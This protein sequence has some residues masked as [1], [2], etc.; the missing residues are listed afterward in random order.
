MESTAVTSIAS[1]HST[2]TVV[3]PPEEMVTLD[4]LPEECVFHILCNLSV[5]DI[6]S[7]ACVSM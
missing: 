1:L 6:G 3:D 5:P 2:A 4:E 7:V